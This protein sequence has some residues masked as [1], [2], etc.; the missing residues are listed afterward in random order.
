MIYDLQKASMWKRV[1]AW[2]FDTILLSIVAVGFAFLL[3]TILGYDKYNDRLQTAYDRY[4]SE[5][6]ISFDIAEEDYLALDPTQKEVYDKA[7][8][9]LS[10]DG[11]A[12]Y[13]YNMV[14][15]LTLIILSVGILLAYLLLEFVI[16][17]FL[18]NG[19]T[20][21][22]KI[23]GICLMRND[24]VRLPTLSLLVRTLL[25]KYTVETMVPVL[26]LVMIFFNFLGLAGT[27]TILGLLILQI[28]VLAVTKTNSA[29]HDLL[30]GTVVV[31][32][33]SQMIFEN[34][35]AMLEYKKKI[36]AEAAAKTDY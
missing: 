5:Y 6:G 11:E 23:F 15:Y 35:E 14:I 29:I 2:L 28:V 7:Y 4:E 3:S 27:L 33:S 22:K 36:A 20:L 8:T 13:A 34:E 10:E 9:A 30:A 18:K 17:L 1:S 21:G 24:G 26:I 32:M 16:P 31:D 12:L 25:G 19:Q